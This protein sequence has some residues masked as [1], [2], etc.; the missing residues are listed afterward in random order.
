MARSDNNDANPLLWI[1]FLIAL[2]ISTFVMDIPELDFKDV[3][4]FGPLSKG[5][6]LWS[7]TP[8]SAVVAAI[9]LVASAFILHFLNDAYSSGLNFILPLL[10]LILV[11]A[12][13]SAVYMTPMHIAALLFI[14]SI[15]L[16]IKFKAATGHPADFFASVMMLMVA[17]CFFVP[18]IW[19]LPFQILSGFPY[20]DNKLQYL[21]TTLFSILCGAASIMGIAYLSAGFEAM[22]ALPGRCLDILMTPHLAVPQYSI[23]QFARIGIVV[24]LVLIAIFRNFRNQGNYK[25]AEAKML[26]SVMVCSAVIL[27]LMLLY[28]PDCSFPFGMIALAPAS[29]VIFG[30][31]GD[32][33]KTFAT[34]F[35]VAVMFIII[36]ERLIIYY[37]GW[38]VPFINSLIN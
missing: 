14:I 22:C 15:A 7:H 37:G 35:S 31:F 17:S 1:V 21:C 12:N 23:M 2:Y 4:C 24:L 28:L 6:I 34:V 38:G 13:P 33:K 19:V 16:F 18:L 32:S 26:R 8:I 25:I 30:L 36:A 20:A 3:T 5:S 11:I 10:Y 27:P 9:F 29:I